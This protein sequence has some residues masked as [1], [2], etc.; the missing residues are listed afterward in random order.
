MN[1]LMIP[2]VDSEVLIVSKRYKCG[3]ARTLEYEHR[4]CTRGQADRS[5]QE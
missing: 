1:W 3:Q 2:P 4:A 5:T